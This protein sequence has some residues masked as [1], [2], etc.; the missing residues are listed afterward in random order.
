[1]DS[2]HDQDVPEN[3]DFSALYG[4]LWGA[5]G[6]MLLMGA[7][8]GLLGLVY[9]HLVSPKY[10]VSLLVTQVPSEKMSGSG[11]GLSGMLANSLNIGALTGAGNDPSFKLYLEAMFSPAVGARLATDAALMHHVF[12]DQWDAEQQD[13]AKPSDTATSVKDTLKSLLAIPVRPWHPPGA[14][15]MTSYVFDNMS[16]DNNLRNQIVVLTIRTKDPAAGAELLT[17]LNLVTD[18]YLRQVALTRS[19]AYVNYILS[20]LKEVTVTEYRQALI[21][22]L[23]DQEKQHMM[24]SSNVPFSAQT[25]G[26]PHAT[27]KPVSPKLLIVVPLFIVVGMFLTVIMTVLGSRFFLRLNAGVLALFGRRR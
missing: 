9:L 3:T 21:N 19:D 17:K 18:Q 13:W 15:E 7:L 4:Q 26:A 24:A 2:S 16:V 12:A 10:D 20:K 11:G 27:S 25:F 23:S 5:R 8:F 6:G 1:M 14:D 22:T